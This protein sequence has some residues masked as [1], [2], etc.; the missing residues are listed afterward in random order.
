MNKYEEKKIKKMKTDEKICKKMKK[1]EG[2]LECNCVWMY[3]KPMGKH[4]LL[5]RHLTVTD[6]LT[7]F[8]NNQ[9]QVKLTGGAKECPGPWWVL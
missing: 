8:N 5:N 9:L 2:K 4:C 1:G 3:L 6:F 7:T